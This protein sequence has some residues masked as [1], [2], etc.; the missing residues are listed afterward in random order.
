MLVFSCRFSSINEG[1]SC[2]ILCDLSCI[3]G[4]AARIHS[5]GGFSDLLA[6]LVGDISSCWR[7]RCCWPGSVSLLYDFFCYVFIPLRFLKSLHIHHLF[8]AVKHNSLVSLPS[9]FAI[10]M[11]LKKPKT[12]RNLLVSICKSYDAGLASNYLS[13]EDFRHFAGNTCKCIRKE[14][15]RESYIN[16]LESITGKYRAYADPHPV[17]FGLGASGQIYI[18]FIQSHPRKVSL[19]IR[20]L[21]HIC[22]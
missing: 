15:F 2:D 14:R 1:Y 6:S 19:L 21:F 9:E 16:C 10:K 11:V 7:T 4:C 18:F 17:N 8:S 12:D 5:N 20:P 22:S 3:S 13:Y